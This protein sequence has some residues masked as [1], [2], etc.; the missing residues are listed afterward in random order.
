MVWTL[1]IFFYAKGGFI[2]PVNMGD[3]SSEQRCEA[4]A[5]R[6]KNDEEESDEIKSYRCIGVVR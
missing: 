4:V 1:V 2:S 5:N 3:F 6:L